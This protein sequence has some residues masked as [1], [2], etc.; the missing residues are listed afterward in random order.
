[1]QIYTVYVCKHVVPS[2]RNPSPPASV[3]LL[4]LGRSSLIMHYVVVPLLDN[5][6]AFGDPPRDLL[7]H[8]AA[9]KKQERAD[10]C[11][12]ATTSKATPEQML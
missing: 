10:V 7:I 1:M 3:G 6:T 12:C 5:R 8:S 4:L 11:L 2:T 9:V